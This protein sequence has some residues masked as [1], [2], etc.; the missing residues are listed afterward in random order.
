MAMKKLGNAV[1]AAVVTKVQN[2]SRVGTLFLLATLVLGPSPASALPRANVTNCS[3]SWVNNPGA[4]KC[5]NEGE[6]DL[7]NNRPVHYVGCLSDG[8]LF[9]CV[10]NA[11]GGQDC[12]AIEDK[13]LG[14][15]SPLAD[16]Q[17]SNELGG[18]QTTNI[19]LGQIQNK[20]DAMKTELDNLNGQCGGLQ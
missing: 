18:V 1:V 9:C 11:Q 10:D 20:L 14:V 12:E 3:S 16:L 7:L 6:Q 13:T 17:L 19:V 2:W 15:R 4:N 8:T 5:V